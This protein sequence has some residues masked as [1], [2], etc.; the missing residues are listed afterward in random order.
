[1]GKGL[2]THR[3]LAFQKHATIAGSARNGALSTRRPASR[4]KGA[5]RP[6]PDPPS[7][8]TT[9]DLRAGNAR[10]ELEPRTFRADAALGE[11]RGP[12]RLRAMVGHA[13]GDGRVSRMDEL[14]RG[15][16]GHQHQW[17]D[18]R[19]VSGLSVIPIPSRRGRWGIRGW[20]MFW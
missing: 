7:P 15:R 17:E 3:T 1:M 13:Q 9:D 20:R 19:Q 8:V 18:A 11:N 2:S 12:Y 4:G 5:V 14:T 6:P 16:A 10:L